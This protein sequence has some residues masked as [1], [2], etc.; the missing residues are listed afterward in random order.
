[1]SGRAGFPTPRPAGD[2]DRRRRAGQHAVRF[3]ISALDRAEPSQGGAGAARHP[4]SDPY[5]T[6]RFAERIG[7]SRYAEIVRLTSSV[8]DLAGDW[9]FAAA[10]FDPTLLDEA[11]YV[12]DVLRRGWPARDS[13]AAREAFIDR[14]LDV[15][16]QV[17]PF[18]DDLVE[19]IASCRPASWASRACSSSTL[20][21]SP[22]RGRSNGFSRTFSSFSEA[23]TA[24]G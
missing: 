11:A 23:R 21:R 16:A 5:L 18:L 19:H 22:W 6:L 8:R 4:G 15:R 10:L 12:N 1:M 3:A 20:R 9:V 2:H 24:K 7:T 17:H 14:L 13:F